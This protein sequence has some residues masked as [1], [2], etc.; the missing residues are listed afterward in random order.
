MEFRRDAR[1]DRSRWETSRSLESFDGTLLA[2]YATGPSDAPAMVLCPG[3]GGSAPTWRPFVDRFGDRFRL[4]CWDYRGL[5]QSGSP[6]DPAAYDLSHHV[7]DLTTLL[8]HEGVKDP[9]LVGWSMGVQVGLEL[10]REHP[11]R[12]A[13]FVAI[14]GTSGRPLATAFDSSLP[15]M[16]A[17]VVLAALRQVGDR[18]SGVGPWLTQSPSV[19][20]SFIWASQ[21]LGL[22]SEDV[23]FSGFRDMAEE[24][25]GLDL[26]VYAK[27]FEALVDHDAT[28]L[29]ETIETPTLLIAGGRDR[30]TPAHVSEHVAKRMPNASFDLVDGATH[31]G[32][33]EFPDAILES[34]ERFLERI[35]LP[36]Y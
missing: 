27:I 8:D 3:L 5:Y 14:H 36:V 31:F 21:Q 22:M 4:L 16:A 11:K 33:L 9:V 30:L 7:R 18:F 15:G 13:G 20:R 12:A 1:A 28:D 19:V 24:W 17:P 26:A 2:Y 23:D 29:L 32:L 10:H 34:V 6:A 35:D 25:C